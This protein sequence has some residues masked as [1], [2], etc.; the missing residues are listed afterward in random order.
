MTLEILLDAWP[1]LA[2][3]AFGLAVTLTTMAIAG[4]L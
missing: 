1:V 3:F 2:A 4:D